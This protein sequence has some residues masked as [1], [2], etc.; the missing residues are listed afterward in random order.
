MAK[1]EH[2]LPEEQRAQQVSAT[3][4]ENTEHLQAEI[5]QAQH[6]QQEYADGKHQ[7]A[8]IFKV[9][10]KVWFNAQNVTTQWPSRKL[11]HRHIGPYEI[12]KVILPYAN[13]LQFPAS[14]KHHPV[15]HVSLLDLVGNDPLP[16]QHNPP[17]P[18]VIVDDN[19]EWHVEEILDSRIYYRRL[20]Y[21]VKWIVFDRP[22]WEPAEGV[23]KV[24]AV[25]R[26]HQHYSEKPGPLPEDED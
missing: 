10:D 4:K 23:N 19:E 13:R 20:Q 2:S 8:P 25:D 16:G 14:V 21:L 11:D 5:F 15:Q 9:G 12:I 26:F 7:P 1:L 3:M 22:D 18:P 6:R 17:P 24:E